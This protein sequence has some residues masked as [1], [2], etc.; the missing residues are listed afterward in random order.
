MLRYVRMV[1]ARAVATALQGARGPVHLNFPFREPLVPAPHTTSARHWK[2]DDA[3]QSAPGTTMLVSRL[4]PVAAELTR[5]ARRG[6]IVCGPQDDFDAER[7][8]SRARCRTCW[9]CPSWPTRSR[10]CEAAAGPTARHRRL[11]HILCASHEVVDGLQPDLILR[12]GAPPTSKP[13]ADLPAAP[14]T[15]AR[16][17]SSP[18][19]TWRDPDLTADVVINADADDSLHRAGRALARADER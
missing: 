6:L 15:C 18:G 8:G 12:F 3:R 10:R 7:T 19:Q 14:P 1:A 4:S 2:A 17:S 11:R 13:L 5:T 16:S 9:L